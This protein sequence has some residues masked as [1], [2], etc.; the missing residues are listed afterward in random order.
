MVIKILKEEKSLY[1]RW[2]LSK[3]AI[4]L[5]DIVEVL[6][7]DTYGGNEKSAIRIGF[8]YG[9]TDRLIIKTK[10]ETY[11]LYTSTGGLKEEILSYVNN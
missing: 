9:N 11:I 3:V 7:D 6:E 10:T 4:P 2:Q 1:I 8:P 5:S